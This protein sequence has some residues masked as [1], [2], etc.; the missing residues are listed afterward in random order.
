M[1][2]SNGSP[3]KIGLMN[4]AHDVYWKFFPGHLEPATELAG[5][6][7]RYVSQFGQLI[8]TGKLVD[9]LENR[10]LCSKPPQTTRPAG[11]IDTPLRPRSF[12]PRPALGRGG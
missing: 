7:N 9:S 12:D 4:L 8:E 10:L 6:M 5:D 11:M 1:S 2:V 3:L